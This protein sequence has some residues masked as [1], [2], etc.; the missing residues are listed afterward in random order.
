VYL[1]IALLKMFGLDFL[2]TNPFI[3]QWFILLA[4]NS[5]NIRKL[6]VLPTVCIYVFS[7]VLRT[8]I[9]S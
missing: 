5:L 8:E 7:M 4:T 9:T 6:Y 1:V 3:V 2:Y